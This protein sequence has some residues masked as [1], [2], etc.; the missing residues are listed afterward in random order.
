MRLYLLRHNSECRNFLLA[1][2]SVFG[3]AA[4]AM[5]QTDNDSS[6][7]TGAAENVI[8]VTGTAYQ[9][10][11]EIEA[12]RR[13]NAIVDTISSDD[14]GVLPDITIA[15]SL[16]RIPGV[17]T[18]FNDDIG[19]FASIRGVNPDLIPITLNG[20][21]IASVGDSGEG[22]RRVNLQVIQSDAIKQLR[23]FKTLSPDLDAGALGGLIDIV[24]ASAFDRDRTTLSATVGSS[25]TTFMKVPD[26]NSG[27]EGKDSPIGKAVSVVWAPRFGADRQF[28]VVITGNYNKRPRTQSNNAI[29]ERLYFNNAG[30][31][32]TPE[33]AD[34][35][36]FA[37]PETFTTAS[38]TN[39]FQ[40]YGSTTRLE[41]KPSE[42]LYSNLFG[43]AYFSDEQETRNTIRLSGLDQIRDQTESMGSLRNKSATAE[44]VYRPF[45]RRQLGG[46][47]STVARFGDHGELS[48]NFGYSHAKYSVNIPLLSF[49]YTS[50][51]RLTYNL[52]NKVSSFVLNNADSY[53]DPAN[54]KLNTAFNNSRKSTESVYGGRLD[55]LYN[56][57]LGDQGL[58]FAAGVDYRKLDLARDNSSLRYT[59]RPVT[60]S[61][62]GFVPDY[63]PPGYP[64]KNL[65]IDQVRFRDEVVPTLAINQSASDYD[66]RIN[67]YKY[68]ENTFA[69]YGNIS[70]SLDE[71][72]ADIGARFDRARFNA[73]TAQVLDRVLQDSPA[74]FSGGYTHVLPYFTGL[75]SLRPSLR[76]KVGVSQTLG[77]PNPADIATVENIDLV[78]LQISRGN[79]DLKP[80]RS[81]NLDAGLE[82]FFNGS[83]GLITV[84]GFYKDIRD[85]IIDVTET[86]VIDGNS[87]D[88]SQPINANS[89]KYKG[90]EI[91]LINSSF[92]VLYEGLRHLGASA[93]LTV[94]DGRTTF[95]YNGEK[96]TRTDLLFQ[97]DLSANATVFYELGSGSEVR[98]AM[99][100]QGRYLETYGAVPWENRSNEPFTT[101]DFVGRL[102]LTRDVQIRLEGR[103]IFGANRFRN[104]GPDLQYFRAGLELGSTWYIRVN[105]HM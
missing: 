8:V 80:R 98:L 81:T 97:P 4:P 29:V 53:L 78:E 34:W 19:Q 91:N 33:S 58:G 92:A 71:S 40:N 103:N 10:Q 17:T 16:R 83:Q 14:I 90:L 85:D 5:A 59:V 69:T 25:Y 6:A 39:R 56:N 94:L 82:Y 28:G 55:Y 88:V 87:F 45:K 21:T 31:L 65:W 70:Y 62:Y 79:P 49:N 52:E 27:G 18:I 63:S 73:T 93:N 104:I 75:L 89:T 86:Q 44:W 2:T 99:N 35:N 24:P 42:T 30:A 54:Y 23:V 100:H 38:Y 15:D 12:R 41:F 76:L 26:D 11:E 37:A 72:R 36:G 105:Y 3:L 32:T 50:G 13:S 84:T 101:F 66:S 77:R 96:R 7:D 64:Y 61:G 22:A 68:K 48:S 20:L 57:G 1:A 9:N 51:N 67:D 95:V 60:L 102:D 46:Q 43:Y 47:W 74:R